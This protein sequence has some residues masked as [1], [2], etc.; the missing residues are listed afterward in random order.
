MGG[1]CSKMDIQVPTNHPK[2]KGFTVNEIDLEVLHYI[3]ITFGN[4][5][6]NNVLKANVKQH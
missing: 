6:Q 5:I 1:V 2:T 4:V 3:S